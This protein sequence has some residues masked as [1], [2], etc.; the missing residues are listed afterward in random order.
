MAKAKYDMCFMNS[1]INE[2]V[3][4]LLLSGKKGR[5]ILKHLIVNTFIMSPP[6]TSCTGYESMVEQ[7]IK[8]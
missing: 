5:T 6:D 2:G 1:A 4:P 3:I 7:T 8:S